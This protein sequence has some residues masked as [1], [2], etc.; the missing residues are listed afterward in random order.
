M[1][2]RKSILITGCSSGIGLDA[3][4]TL[5]DCG[6]RVFATCR[7][8]HDCEELKLH[9]LESFILDY[10]S[11]DTIAL[12]LENVFQLTGGTLDALFN[13]GAYAI[14]GA[15]EDLPRDALRQ[16]FEANVFGWHDLIVR[17]I[18]IMSCLLYTSPSPRDGLLS[19]MPSSA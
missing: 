4:L 16:N 17:V 10:E 3:A 12:A 11:P 1:V 15:I 5:N 14:P 6:W 2:K 18:P 13:N 8:Q 19:R 7:K 9:G